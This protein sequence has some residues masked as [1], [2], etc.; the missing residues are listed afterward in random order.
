MLPV[1]PLRSYIVRHSTSIADT[2][3]CWTQSSKSWIEGTNFTCLNKLTNDHLVTAAQKNKLNGKTVNLNSQRIPT[4]GRV[5]TARGRES[6]E[7]SRRFALSGSF[8]RGLSL[9]EC[10]GFHNVWRRCSINSGNKQLTQRRVT[11]KKRR[12]RKEKNREGVLERRREGFN[13]DGHSD[14]VSKSGTFIL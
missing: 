1:R 9:C 12:K 10:R 7:P 2:S 8:T 13:L 4:S 5:S 11:L 3:M 14:S 6:L